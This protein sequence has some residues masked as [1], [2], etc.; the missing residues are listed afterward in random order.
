MAF[1][2]VCPELF[3]RRPPLWL[4]P[5]AV[6]Q[7]DHSTEPNRL[8]VLLL[9]CFPKRV[10]EDDLSVERLAVFPERGGRKLKDPAVLEGSS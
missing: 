8:E 10:R 1:G 2:C 3:Y 4:H 7:L 5:R 9:L 6:S